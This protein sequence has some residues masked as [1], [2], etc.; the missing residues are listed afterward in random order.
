MKATQTEKLLAALEKIANPISYFQKELKEGERLEGAIVLALSNDANWLKEVAR[1]A[2]DNYKSS[3]SYTQVES[4]GVCELDN[5][6]GFSFD[7]ATAP[8]DFKVLMQEVHKVWRQH[9][10]ENVSGSWAKNATANLFNEYLK[11]KVK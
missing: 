2:I 6:L 1:E 4:A 7:W 11:S 5:K 10:A 9:G 8:D 3:P